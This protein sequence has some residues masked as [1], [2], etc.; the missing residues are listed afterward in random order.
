MT[1]AIQ[2]DAEAAKLRKSVDGTTMMVSQALNNMLIKAEGVLAGMVQV[3][4][5]KERG[6]E[7]GSWSGGGGARDR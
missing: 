3:G 6:E 5:E 7:E 4:Q 1:A 2:A